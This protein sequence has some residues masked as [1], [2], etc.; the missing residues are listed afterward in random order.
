MPPKTTKKPSVSKAKKVVTKVHKRRAAKNMDT[1]FLKA[2]TVM[3]VVPAQGVTVANYSYGLAQLLGGNLLTNSEFNF[4]ALQYDRFRV[5]SVTIKW[6]PKA[7]VLDQASGQDDTKYNVT[8]DGMIHTCIDRDAQA[9]SSIAAISRYPSYRKFSIMKKWSRT[10]K[11]VYPLGTWLDCQNPTQNTQ[12]I[13]TLGLAGNVTW[14]AEN[15]LEDNYELW[16]EPVAEISLEWNVVYQGKTSGSL[17]FTTDE[18]GNVTGVK[19]TPV[20]P[21]SNLP[22]T[23]LL[24]VRG[25]IKDTRTMDEVTEQTIDDQG[26]PLP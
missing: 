17:S 9:P 23:P 2:K 4:Y 1:F 15:F 19:I 18:G 3:N 7:N 20:S 26:Q 16:N 24:N 5:N 12:V 21:T 25:S 10:Y 8:G 11:A 22:L 13:N 6:T 14:Y